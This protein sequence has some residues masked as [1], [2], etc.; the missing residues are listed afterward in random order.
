MSLVGSITALAAGQAAVD[1]N[2]LPKGYYNFPKAPPNV[3]PPRIRKPPYLPIAIDCAGMMDM[4]P[5][6][7]KHTLCGDINRGYIP[8]NPMGQMLDGQPYPL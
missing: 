2:S 7:S 6:N 5:L 8:R 4:N 3:R 1:E